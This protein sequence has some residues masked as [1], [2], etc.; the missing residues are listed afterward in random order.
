MTSSQI[1]P[2]NI[3]AEYPVA[4]QDNNT[5]GFR[6][7]FTNIKLN[8]QYASGEINSLFGNAILKNNTSNDF[9]NSIVYGARLQNTGYVQIN[10]GNAAPTANINFAAGSF[11]T[12][13]ANANT[14]L[15]FS[16]LPTAGTTAVLTLAIEARAANSTASPYT[17]TV[18]NVSSASRGITGYDPNTG[19]LS[20]PRTN[21]TIA[22]T[23]TYQF[24]TDD[25]GGSFTIV[26]LS[27]PT[28]PL[29]S[30]SEDVANVGVINLSV[31]DSYFSTSGVETAT[32]PAGVNGQVKVLAMY[33]NMDDS[34]LD[35]MVITVTNAGWKTSG[36]GTITFEDIG[37]ACTL[38][39]I[40]S[41][42]FCIGN[43][44]CTFA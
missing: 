27:T 39:Y 41:K 19:I 16:N 36:T 6:D 42:W 38:K 9:A 4:G 10:Q 18:P 12:I 3:N 2:N 31:S 35:N 44:G 1:N 20:F 29:N 43:N 25:Q 13:T 34:S 30:T 32:L 33:A 22:G 24:I 15:S 37:H 40:N 28:T 17:I 11:Q 14:T 21:S 7:N 5:Q 8:F 26:P 23:H